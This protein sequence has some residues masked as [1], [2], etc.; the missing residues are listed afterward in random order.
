M[1]PYIL[2]AVGG[3]LIGDSAKSDAIKMADGGKTR[4]WK[5]GVYDDQ[6]EVE[7]FGRKGVVQEGYNYPNFEDFKWEGYF[8]PEYDVFHGATKEE[9]M[10]QMKEWAEDHPLDETYAKGGSIKSY[11]DFKNKLIEIANREGSKEKFAQAVKS[12]PISNKIPIYFQEARRDIL[13]ITDN[14]WRIYMSKPSQ[15]LKEL[16]NVSLESMYEKL[17]N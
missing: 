16:S 2:A 12:D 14:Q 10:E 17:K 9:V 1:I 15:Y 6:I 7:F 5:D 11:K 4:G 3:Y 13:N 8:D